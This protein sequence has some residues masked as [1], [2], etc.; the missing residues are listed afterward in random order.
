M[1]AAVLDA[2]ES[3]R[4]FGVPLAR[5]GIQPVFLRIVNRSASPMRLHLVSID[6]NYYTPLEAAGVNHFSIVKRFSAFGLIAWFFLPLLAL[7]IP[8]K[9][10]GARRANRRMDELFRSAAFHLR[11]IPPGE[12]SEGFVFTRLDAGTKIVHVRRS[13]R[14]GGGSRR[15]AI[16]SRAARSIRRR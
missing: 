3:D 13:C 1:T 12:A 2:A 7:I 16:S 10:I 4:M 15:L 9:L 11:P 6:P 14:G 8:F 5:R